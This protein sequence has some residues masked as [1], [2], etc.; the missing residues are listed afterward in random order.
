M[1]IK[2]MSGNEVCPKC[3][4]I[5]SEHDWDTEKRVQTCP[6]KR[7][8]ICFNC[9]NKLRGCSCMVG[10][11][12]DYKS[13]TCKKFK[14]KETKEEKEKKRIADKKKAI[15]DQKALVSNANR[16]YGIKGTLTL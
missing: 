4:Q 3:G 8:T 10:A 12:P 14:Q 2:K 15:A 11:M 6:K 5:A 1:T 7:I 9:T 13:N 16:E